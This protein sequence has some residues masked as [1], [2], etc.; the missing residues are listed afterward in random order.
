MAKA[1][2]VVYK[3]EIDYTV[4]ERC[5]CNMRDQVCHMWEDGGGENSI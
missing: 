2:N 5:T 4:K 3:Y 1:S